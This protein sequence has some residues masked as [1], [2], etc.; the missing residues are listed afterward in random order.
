[1]PVIAVID[2]STGSGKSR[3][4][5][6]LAFRFKALHVNVGS[7]YRNIAAT[8]IF[9]QS[10]L[11]RSPELINLAKSIEPIFAL[12]PDGYTSFKP[13][14]K[15]GAPNIMSEKVAEVTSKIA[16]IPELQNIVAM[17]AKRFTNTTKLVIIEGQAVGRFFAPD[18][19]VKFFVDCDLEIRI[20]RR[21]DHFRKTNEDIDLISISKQLIKR[22][23]LDSTRA[24]YPYK[25]AKKAV[26][27]DNSAGSIQDLATLMEEEISYITKIN[28]QIN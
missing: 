3:I 25:P 8:I 9:E 7:I 14:L 13:D 6:L 28:P 4:A 16:L 18:A 19:P 1:M 2:G 11:S 22:D 24:N 21:I 5:K 17:I 10:P 20:K 12:D 15:K 26:F 27:I 23:L